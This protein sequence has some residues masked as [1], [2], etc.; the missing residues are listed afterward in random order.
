MA[1]ALWL[2]VKSSVLLVILWMFAVQ[3][4]GKLHRHQL[5]K[6]M[7]S[8]QDT[9]INHR[10]L[11]R[12][13]MA[14]SQGQVIADGAATQNGELALGRNILVAFMPWEGFNFEDAIL[15]S[16]RLVRDD[17]FTSIHIEKLEI[18][19]RTT[20]LGPEEITREIPNVSED[21]MRHLDDGVLCALV[22][23]YLL[24]IFWLVK[25]PLKV[26]QSTLLRKN[27]CE[28]SLPK[29]QRCA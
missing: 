20:K 2:Q 19:A 22:P 14:V 29:K 8:N 6:Y 26:N 11:V 13:G 4:T 12:E 28:P 21:S 27:C 16:Q 1:M 24:M 15:I 17:V 9:C 25:S 18:D 10:P 23:V 5:I 7:R 3:T